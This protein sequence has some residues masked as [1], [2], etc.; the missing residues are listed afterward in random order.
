MTMITR[1]RSLSSRMLRRPSDEGGFS[2]IEVLTGLVLT[3]ITAGGLSSYL[4]VSAVQQRA[5]RQDLGVWNAA[6]TQMERLIAQ[7]YSSVANGGATVN[8]FPMTWQVNG[9]SPK[10]IVLVVQAMGPVGTVRPDTFITSL[11]N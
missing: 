1:F 6:H 5:A 8:G 4:L 7:G 10:E 11:S 2:L 9:A 3:M